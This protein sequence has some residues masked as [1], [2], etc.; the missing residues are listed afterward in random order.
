MQ[1]VARPRPVLQA[2]VDLAPLV[3]ADHD[4]VPELRARASERPAGSPC[5]GAGEGLQHLRRPLEVEELRLARQLGGVGGVE[6][7]GLR[8][9]DERPGALGEGL[10]V[11]EARRSPSAAPARARAVSRSQQ[12]VVDG[13]AGLL[14]L[15]RNCTVQ[16]V[17]ET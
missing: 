11:D 17:S 13:V 12:P 10:A 15:D 1:A 16:A 2:A 9:R 7:A 14:R 4:A 8:E 5:A 3:E 6:L